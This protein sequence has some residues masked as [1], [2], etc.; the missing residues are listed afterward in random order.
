MTTDVAKRRGCNEHAQI[1]VLDH[2]GFWV[3][4][5]KPDVTGETG[6][7]GISRTSAKRVL[8]KRPHRVSDSTGLQTNVKS[9][10]RE[11]VILIPSLPPEASCMRSLPEQV[12]WRWGAA[13]LGSI[14]YEAGEYKMGDKLQGAQNWWA[15]FVDTGQLQDY[16]LSIAGV[17][18]H[19]KG[20]FTSL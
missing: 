5:W 11:A 4:R 18:L 9:D 7:P 16:P 6:W 17:P 2:Q 8:P 1:K 13:A 15:H 19:R 14:A 3:Y 12:D 10:V 20:S